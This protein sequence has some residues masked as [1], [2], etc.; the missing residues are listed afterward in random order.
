M[1]NF[2]RENLINAVEQLGQSSVGREFLLWLLNEAEVFTADFPQNEK[3]TAWQAG[4][5]ALG[6]Q[7]LELCARA[8]NLGVVLTAEAM[9]ESSNTA[10]LEDTSGREAKEEDDD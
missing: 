2:K 5:R 8:G 1:E 6:L 7:V 10:G 9:Y 3:R 4:R